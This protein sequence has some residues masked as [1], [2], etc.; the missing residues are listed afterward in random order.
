[1]AD[2]GTVSPTMLMPLPFGV[3]LLKVTVCFLGAIDIMK[4]IFEEAF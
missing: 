1:M 3:V 2:R 4:E